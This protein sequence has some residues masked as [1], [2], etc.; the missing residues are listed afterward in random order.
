MRSPVRSTGLSVPRD[1][2]RRTHQIVAFRPGKSATGEQEKDDG[3]ASTSG[4]AAAAVDGQEQYEFDRTAYLEEHELDNGPDPDESLD[5]T[6][7]VYEFWSPTI[8]AM[9]Y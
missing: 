4:G 9:P 1:K 2:T 6:E 3:V 8:Q 7:S 5:G